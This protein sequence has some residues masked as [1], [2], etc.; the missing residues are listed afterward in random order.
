MVTSIVLPLALA[1]IMFTLGLGLKPADF[2]RVFVYPRGISIG[3]VNLALVSPLLAFLM[4]IIF[5]LEPFMAVGLVL[6]GASPGG[7]LANMFTHLAKGETALSVSMTAISSVVAVFTIPLFLD[8]SNRYFEAGNSLDDVNM[9]F[10]V[11]RTILIT[12]VPLALGMY[13]ANRAPDWTER[14]KPSLSKAGIVAF[15]LVVIAA[16]ISEWHLIQE[17][18][19]KVAAAALALNIAAMAISFTASRFARLSDRQSTAIALELGIHN[20]TVAIV[21]AGMIDDRLMIPA[22]VYSAFQFITGGIF[23][24]FM[25]SRN[26]RPEAGIGVEQGEPDQAVT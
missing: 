1:F 10:V 18:F 20:A 9:L 7:T 2:K 6:L 17:N 19:A 11:I 14:R 24:K 22:A 23:A 13:V 8:L 12:I 15:I 3:M 4:A 21:V 25:H 5:D 26:A 16:V